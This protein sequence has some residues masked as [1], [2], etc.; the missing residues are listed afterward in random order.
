MSVN[1]TAPNP[2]IASQADLAPRHPMS[3][4]VWRYI[5]ASTKAIR[6]APKARIAGAAQSTPLEREIADLVQLSHA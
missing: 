2:M 6:R 5:M 4:L 1:S 3:C